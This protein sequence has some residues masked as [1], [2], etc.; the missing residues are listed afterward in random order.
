[1]YLLIHSD[2]IMKNVSGGLKVASILKFKKNM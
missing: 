2:S 1:M